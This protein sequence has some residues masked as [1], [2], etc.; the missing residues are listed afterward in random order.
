M[1]QFLK[2]D[3]K[4][5]IPLIGSIVLYLIFAYNLERSNFL[6]LLLLYSG[7]FYC[8]WRIIKA[9][10]FNFWVLAGIGVFFRLLFLPVIPNLSQDFYRFVW[11]GRVLIQGINPY[12]FTPEQLQEGTPTALSL[13]SLD[14]IAQW[15][16]LINGMGAL[17]AHHYSNYPPINQL[18]FAIAALFAKGSILGS[19]IVLR[20]LMIAADIG[21]LYFGKKLLEKLN[22][23]VKNIFWYS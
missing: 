11:D 21:I 1:R 7:L 16:E 19:V 17:N 12:L 2:E 6:N 18:C 13:T 5:I 3:S 20:V 10:Q 15:Q 9:T 4:L 8:A 23:P 22:L 14:T